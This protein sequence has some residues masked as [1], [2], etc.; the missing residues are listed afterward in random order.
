[1][2][3]RLFLRAYNKNCWGLDRPLSY[4]QLTALLNEIG[5]SVT[6]HDAKNGNKGTVY[7]NLV[8]CTVLTKPLVKKL[9]KAI[10]E[11]DVSKIFID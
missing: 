3:K 2:L 8:P 1:L 5:F 4:S 10:P 7:T 9:K 11:L 6:G